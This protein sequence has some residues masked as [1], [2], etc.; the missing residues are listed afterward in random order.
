ML[1][2]DQILAIVYDIKYLD[3][4]IAVD[5]LDPNES[6]RLYLQVRVKNGIDN[7]NGAPY[8]WK[9]RKWALSHH[10]TE[11]EI[12]KT[13]LVAIKAAVEHEALEN[14]KYKGVTIFDPHIS[15]D[16]LLDLREDCE[17]DARG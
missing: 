2:T 1:S 12:V 17:L 10:M 14:F 5:L 4:E 16:D 15:V 11:T 13:A 7:T 8:S 9:G 3:W 6:D